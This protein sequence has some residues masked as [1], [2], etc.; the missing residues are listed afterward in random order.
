MNAHLLEK[1]MSAPTAH[2]C[3]FLLSVMLTLT[4]FQKGL[5]DVR[6]DPEKKLIKGLLSF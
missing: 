6:T 5:T 2:L 4:H 3:N 1:P